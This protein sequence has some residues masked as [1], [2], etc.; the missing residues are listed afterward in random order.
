MKLYLRRETLGWLKLRVEGMKKAIHENWDLK[1]VTIELPSFWMLTTSLN[2]R[3]P[4]RL[5]HRCP[6]F[7][8]RQA[9]DSCQTGRVLSMN[10]PST[11]ENALGAALDGPLHPL[12]IMVSSSSGSGSAFT[13][14]T[15]ARVEISSSSR[16]R[17]LLNRGGMTLKSGLADGGG[18]GGQTKEPNQCN[19]AE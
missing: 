16:C 14:E 3:P 6:R 18:G 19:D 9:G 2:L 11:R 8:R 5:P 1:Y 17:L 12:A 10:D 13:G 4:H 7:V 15:A